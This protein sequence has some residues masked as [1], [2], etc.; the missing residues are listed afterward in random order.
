MKK[1]KQN[2]RIKHSINITALVIFLLCL[3]I[4][5]LNVI[6]PT[7]GC[8]T[9][10]LWQHNPIP[11]F[12]DDQSKMDITFTAVLFSFM[13]FAIS[14]LISQWRETKKYRQVKKEIKQKH[15]TQRT[16]QTTCVA[17][18]KYRSQQNSQNINSYNYF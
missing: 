7:R 5:L 2:E 3:T 6:E 10:W 9:N 17:L 14:K 11:F 13:S 15:A 12:V 18:G 16:N 4:L 1:S 8:I